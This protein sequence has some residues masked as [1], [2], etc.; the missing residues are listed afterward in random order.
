MFVCQNKHETAHQ[1][2]VA[3]II[4]STLEEDVV[5]EWSSCHH[6]DQR[7]ERLDSCNSDLLFLVSVYALSQQVSNQHQLISCLVE[8]IC[9][10]YEVPDCQ[11]LQLNHGSNIACVLGVLVVN[12]L[13]DGT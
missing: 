2:E 7:C 13:G 10:P 1:L 3:F 9:V 8:G 6:R 11:S 12:T 4:L 5:S